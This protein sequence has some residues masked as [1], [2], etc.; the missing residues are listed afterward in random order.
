[1]LKSLE[2]L[3]PTSVPINFYHHNVA[4]ELKP[5]TLTID[6]SLALIRLTRETIPNAQRIMVAGGRE[7]MFGDR[8][9]EIFKNGANSIVVGDYLTTTGR[10]ANKDL[11][12]LK[13]LHLEVA[14]KVN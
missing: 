1:M 11:A 3:H 5:N 6:E 4:L 14:K 12:M 9:E 7:L 13:S 10:L 2:S 8:Q